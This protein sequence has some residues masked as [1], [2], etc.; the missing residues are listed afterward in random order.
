MKVI[1]SLFAKL[2]DENNYSYKGKKSYII[3][4]D[5]SVDDYLNFANPTPS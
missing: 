1:I 5:S 3:S 2:Q 4:F